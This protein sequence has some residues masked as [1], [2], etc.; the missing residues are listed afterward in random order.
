MSSPPKPS[1]L[2]PPSPSGGYFTPDSL[3]RAWQAVK[4]AGGGAG[5]DGVTLAEFAARLDGELLAL[6][7]ELAGGTYRPQPLRQIMVPKRDGGLRPLALWALRDRV[8]QRAVYEIIAP[9]FESEFLDCS[10]G[11][12]PGRS[13]EAAVKRLIAYRDEHRQ[14]V[15]NADIKSCFDEIDGRRLMLLVR[16]HVHDRVLLHYVRGW[17]EHQILNSADGVPRK[18]GASQG[19]VLSPLLANVYLHPFDQAMTARGFATLR[20]ADNFVI[21]CR[22]KAEAEEARTAAQ[23]GLQAIGLQLNESK[24]A[25]VS[26][27][28]G[29]AWLGYFF[30]RRECYRL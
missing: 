14:W 20:Y 18:A 30:V 4:Q 1:S 16:R 13:V 5:V 9:P 27:D 23:A 11:F 24:T 3:R 21:C 6:Q 22:R 29:F 19:S 7:R 2:R 25:I 8:A 10:F 15:V 28:T 26:F 17:I 12:R